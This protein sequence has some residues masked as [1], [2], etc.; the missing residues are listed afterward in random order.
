M[1]K[2]FYLLLVL[3]ASQSGLSQCVDLFFSEYV[4]G[5]SSNRA[6]EIYNPTDTVV[7]L[8][9][10]ILYRYNNGSVTPTDSLLLYGMIDSNGV[11]VIANPNANGA[12]LAQADTLHTITFFNGDD[13]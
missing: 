2:C 10:Y 4:E 8:N 11:Y 9:N 3:S 7:D 6:L 1:K 12:I 13:P 5:S